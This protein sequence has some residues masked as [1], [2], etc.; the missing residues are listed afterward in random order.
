MNDKE[1]LIDLIL[2]LG[3]SYEFQV[4]WMFFLSYGLISK[5][6]NSFRVKFIFWL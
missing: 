6:L 2:F 3:N 5:L 1:H 4:T